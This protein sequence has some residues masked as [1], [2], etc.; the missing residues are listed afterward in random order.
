M[1]FQQLVNRAYQVF[2]VFEKPEHAT[3]YEHCEECAG[4]D[5]MLLH[6]GRKELTTEQI[7]TVSWGPVPFLTPE[8]M[9]Y[10]MPRLIEIAAS[11][12]DNRDRD[13]YFTHFINSVS[14]GPASRQYALFK[15]PQRLAVASA[16]V[17]IK[18]NH[19]ERVLSFCWEDTLE[20]AMT[21]WSV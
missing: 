6:V 4:Y 14:A 20:T 18:E 1:D 8:A 16:L 5:E 10:Y 13:P 3:N 21:S 12:V 15:T 17:F 19:Y 2:S 9:A 7:G 11:G